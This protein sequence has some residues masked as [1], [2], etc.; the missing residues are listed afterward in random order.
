MGA[1]NALALQEEREVCAWQR[2]GDVQRPRGWSTGSKKGWGGGC[3]WATWDLVG[4]E[5]RFA[6]VL[7]GAVR[8][9]RKDKALTGP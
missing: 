5:S 9:L 7:I 1:G 8:L 2:E 4:E 3:T 6:L